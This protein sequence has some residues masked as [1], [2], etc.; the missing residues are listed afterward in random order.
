M[1]FPTLFA[2]VCLVGSVVAAPV[3]LASRD[4]RVI[5]AALKRVSAAMKKLSDEMKVQAP[6]RPKGGADP[7]KQTITLLALDWEIGEELRY[8]TDLI[9][10][11]PNVNIVEATA[12]T[13]Q[14]NAILPSAQSITDG[15]NELKPMIKAANKRNDVYQQL[16]KDSIATK[17]FSDAMQSKMPYIAQPIGSLY[18]GS[19]VSIV[20]TAVADFEPS[21]F[22]N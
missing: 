8:Q 16:K 12:L 10:R 22:G 4:S 20:E 13:N 9:S 2:A 19:L 21:R 7:N 14:L 17:G 5:D 18:K 3:E 15:W 1:H 6:W 11:G